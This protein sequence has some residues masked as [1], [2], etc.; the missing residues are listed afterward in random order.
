[1]SGPKVDSVNLGP[2]LYKRLQ[3]LGTTLRARN[4]AYQ[5]HLLNRFETEA[6]PM[7][8]P[9]GVEVR[10]HEVFDWKDVQASHEMM[11]VRVGSPLCFL[12]LSFGYR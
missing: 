9:G 8:K 2:I 4:E 12:S 1:M 11:E 7:I 10:I 6:L 5:G 3:I